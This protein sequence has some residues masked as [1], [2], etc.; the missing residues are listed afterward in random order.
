MWDFNETC[1]CSTDFEKSSNTKLMK[2]RAVE[3]ELFHADGKGRRA[4]KETDV[5][6]LIVSFR[7]FANVPKK[8]Q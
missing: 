5:M 4:D 8:G 1:I 2:I 7:N 6:K 3:A